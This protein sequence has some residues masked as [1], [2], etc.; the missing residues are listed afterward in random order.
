VRQFV[1]LVE[2]QRIAR[3]AAMGER[4]MAAASEYV[5]KIGQSGARSLSAC[6]GP[7]RR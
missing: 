7:K 1:E 6:P 5:G 3:A 4:Q 2:P